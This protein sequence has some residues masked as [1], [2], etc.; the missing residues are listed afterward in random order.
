MVVKLHGFPKSIVSDRDKV[1]TSKFWR[2]LFKLS[3]TTL[4]MSSAYHPQFDGQS[5]A[6]NKCLELYLYCFTFENP[7]SWF[8]LLPW[9]EFWYNSSYHNSIGMTP[10]KSVYGRDLPAL[11][12]YQINATE[13]PDLQQNAI[14]A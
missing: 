7:K 10:F 4:A 3:E 1:F 2:H 8:N 12:K 13:L 6:L 5:E 9:A 14:T 11:V